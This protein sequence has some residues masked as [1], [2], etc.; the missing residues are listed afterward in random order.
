MYLVSGERTTDRTDGNFAPHPGSG[1]MIGETGL[2]NCSSA[3]KYRERGGYTWALL[4][5]VKIIVIGSQEGGYS[6]LITY[7]AG[8]QTHACAVSCY[9]V[10]NFRINFEYHLQQALSREVTS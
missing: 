4:C 1:L 6:H 5:K 9:Y 3:R 10:Y 7:Y 2:P 8:A